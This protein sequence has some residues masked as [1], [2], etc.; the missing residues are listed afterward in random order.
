MSIPTREKLVQF[1]PKHDRFIG[2]DSDGCVFDSMELKHKEC[3]IPNII[4]YFNL[5][6][7]SKYAREAAEFVNLYSHWRGANRFPALVKTFELLKTRPEVQR[8][9]A[10]IPDW[11][12]IQK[13]IDEAPSLGNPSLKSA[14]QK[15][16]DPALIHLLE[17]SEA[18]NRDIESMVKGLPPY[19]L[20]K[21]SLKKLLAETDMMVVSA[22]PAEALHREWEEHG[23][24]RFVALIAGQELG[25]KE[26]QLGLTVKG[27]YPADHVLMVGDALGDLKAAR[28]VDALFYPIIPGREEESWR[29]F[30]KEITNQF[31]SGRYTK[32]IVSGHLVEFEKALPETPPWKL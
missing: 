10:A 29:L 26:E 2:F 17:W 3:F 1:Q 25:K 6:P 8:R 7:I 15:N 24:D 20:V 4:K 30:E 27:K 23:I 14:I 9:G 22:T 28:A 5:Q 31:L 12:S 16:P 18:V 13:F 19:P 21:E 11:T 32:D